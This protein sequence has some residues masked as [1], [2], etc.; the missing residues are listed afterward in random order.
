MNSTAEFDKG[1]GIG[2]RQNNI[3]FVLVYKLVDV[4][5]KVIHF[6]C[7]SSIRFAL[8]R[9]FKKSFSVKTFADRVYF[10]LKKVGQ[11][12]PLE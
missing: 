7:I 2:I 3:D 10:H 8:V 4:A 12:K 6:C 9:T 1:K 5:V 11:S